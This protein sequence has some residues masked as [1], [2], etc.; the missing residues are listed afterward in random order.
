MEQMSDTT[1]AHGLPLSLAGQRSR[2]GNCVMDLGT[3][4]FLKFVVVS[5]LWTGYLIDL[6]QKPFV[7]LLILLSLYLGV[8]FVPELMF[9]KTLGK[10]FTRKK[11][12][13]PGGDK[14]GFKNLLGRTFCRLIPCEAFS[15]LFM[16]TGIH[17][18]FSETRV[19]NDL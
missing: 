5:Y 13:T 19:V 10:V 1:I 3:F 4:Y 17:D 16:E 2:L 11:V 6:E 7:H 9:Q 14:P 15:F 12:V 8:Y 18:K